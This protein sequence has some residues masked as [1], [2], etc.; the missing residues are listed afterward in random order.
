MGI[1]EL[2]TFTSEESEPISIDTYFDGMDISEEQKE[3]R[4]SAANDLWWALL[5]LFA[6]IKAGIEDGDLDY[7][8]LNSM[9]GGMVEDIVE[10]Y[11]RKDDYTNAYIRKV[12]Q[13]IIDTTWDHLDFA[14]PDSYWTSGKR[15][16]GVAVN[17]ANSILNYE[18][19]QKAIDDGM[20]HKTW[21][22][23]I[24]PK[25]RDD[26]RYMNGKTI[27]IR[28]YFVFPD[29]KMLV[30]HDEVNGT[31]A[32]TVNCR[33]SVGY[34]TDSNENKVNELAR[35]LSRGK[36]INSIEDLQKVSSSAI[37]SL[38]TQEEINTYFEEKYGISVSGFRP[39]K[40]AHTKKSL[41]GVDDI[42]RKYPESKEAIHSIV[43]DTTIGDMGV[44]SDNGVIRFRFDGSGDYGTGVHEA[45][46]ALDYVRNGKVFSESTTYSQNVLAQA[47]K[48]LGLKA[49]SRAYKDSVRMIVASPGDVSKT[50][51]ILAYSMETAMTGVN[52][53]LAIE[54]ERI[55]R[56]Q[57]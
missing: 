48:N 18:D 39:E 56:G 49:N 10:K 22:A 6:T 26:H 21:K 36:N 11:S 9:F 23:E 37:I 53:S 8:Y 34:I 12:P 44:W 16:V 40:V 38:N 4:K 47:R 28:E 55:V 1:D 7:A 43:Y 42:L 35:G 27:P 57:P 52:N 24:D 31:A 2:N 51:E 3:E 33:C 25:T 50:S 30:P 46:H 17:E 41:A 45:V 15:A 20:T 54:V 5:L 14:K 13:E 19:L 29:C 32:Q